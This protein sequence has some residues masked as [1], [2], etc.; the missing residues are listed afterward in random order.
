MRAARMFASGLKAD[1]SLAETARVTAELYGSLG[2]TGH[3]H[4][5]E[6]AVLL[7]LEGEDPET[8]DTASIDARV[9]TIRDNR[10]L[11]LLGSHELRFDPDHDLV[12]HRRK[13]LPYH[14]NGMIFKAFDAA[15]TAIREHTYYSVGGGF[16]VDEQA[17]GADRIKEDD[18]PVRYPFKTG[19]ELLKHADGTGLPI[20]G[21]M[22]ANE[23][24]WR[25]ES[26]VRSG[27]LRI[28]SVMQECVQHGCDADGVLPGGLKV[29][30]RAASLY[31]RMMA[32][33]YATDPLRVMDWVTLFALAVNEENA[34]GGRVV[35]APTNGAAG[36]IP[37]VLHYYAR[38]VHGANDDGIVRF[39]GRGR[40]RRSHRGYA[41]PG[42]ERRRDR[43][44]AQPRADLRPRRRSGADPLHRTQ[45]RGEH[46]G[47]HRRPPG[48]VGQRPALR[49][50]GQGDQDDARDR[51]R[52]EGQVQGDRPR[53]PRRQRHRVLILRV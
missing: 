25:P 34:A 8:V 45:R 15:G 52:H 43:H 31:Q 32:D 5:S 42:G 26:E 35:T 20:S 46:Q 53:R 22:L 6:K 11:G 19:A 44:G 1:G 18:T 23:T 36:I 7:G 21:L 37:A 51:R 14:P 38:F 10:R 27:L 30:R 17:A 28:W 24:A 13:S 41:A 9:A 39:H 48:A 40:S 12:M 4:G 16:V 3:G 2:A 50:P 29:Q 49:L 47:D 33:P